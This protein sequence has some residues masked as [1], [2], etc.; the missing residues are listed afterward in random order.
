MEVGGR[1]SGK[2]REVQERERGTWEGKSVLRRGQNCSLGTQ[3]TMEGVEAD[4]KRG[5]GALANHMWGDRYLSS[6]LHGENHLLQWDWSHKGPG[7]KPEGHEAIN[8]TLLS[9][10]GHG[11][12]RLD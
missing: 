7:S 8:G 12:K 5:L 9:C 4:S 3:K 2:V 10:M 11:G 1:D 6:G